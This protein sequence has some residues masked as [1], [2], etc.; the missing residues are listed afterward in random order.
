MQYC[1]YLYKQNYLNVFHVY[2][3]MYRTGFIRASKALLPSNIITPRRYIVTKCFNNNKSTTIIPRNENQRIYVDMLEQK[4]PCI[5]VA[6]GTAGTGKTL[7][8][9]HHAAKRLNQG[10]ISK[11]IVTRPAVSVDEQHG[12][13]PGTLEQKMEPWMRPIFDALLTYYSKAKIDNL[14]RDNI[15]EICPLS[16]MRGRTFTNS[17]IIC[18]EAQNT[19]I[20][21]M[22]MILTRIGDNS[23]LVITGDPQQHDRGFHDNGLID[24]ISRVESSGS[25]ICDTIDGD[26][27]SYSCDIGISSKYIG[28]VQFD[29]N[30][31][32]R[33]P[34]I[35]VILD[36]YRDI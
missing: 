3:F 25:D 11:I 14:L 18:D 31:V 5:V 29:E 8:A 16:H 7:L 1:L 13:L 24:F 28:I 27:G 10:E 21:Q 19:T 26:D 9:A 33:H 34:A 20:N 22:L 15:I 17:W 4:Y 23:K 36:M 12:F 32:E 30:D 6:S 35:P 2:F